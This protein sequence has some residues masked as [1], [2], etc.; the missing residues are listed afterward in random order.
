MIAEGQS[1]L[2][3]IDILVNNVGTGRGAGTVPQVVSPIRF[4]DTPFVYDRAPP[5]LGQDTDAVLAELGLS[6]AERSNLSENGVT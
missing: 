5:L 6:A 1:R 3:H 2:G 4:V